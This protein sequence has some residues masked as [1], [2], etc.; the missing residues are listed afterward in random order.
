MTNTWL[1]DA[2]IYQIFIDRFAGY[3]AESDD[4]RPEFC[5]GNLKAIQEKLPYL[6]E[7]GITAIWLT[8]FLRSAD[9]HGYST[10]DFYKV[11]PHFGDLHDLKNLVSA[12]HAQ[13]IRL[14]MDFTANHVSSQ[15][16]FFQAAQNDPDSEYRQWFYFQN[17]G[18]YTCFL[19]FD[20]LPKLNL[21]YQP[22]REHVIGAAEYWL[23]E[24]GLDGFR[25][26]HVIGPSDSF[27]KEFRQRIKALNPEAVMLGEAVIFSVHPENLKTLRVP[28]A[29]TYYYLPK[30]L[31]RRLQ[32][33][34]LKHY[35]GMMDGVIDYTF[36]F[37]IWRYYQGHLTLH[38]FRQILDRHYLQFPSDF[39]LAACVE[40]HDADRIL[41]RTKGS[42]TDM[43]EILRLQFGQNQPQI[44]YYGSEVGMTHAEKVVI[45]SGWA[46]DLPAR[47][48]M[49][50]EPDKH[51]LEIYDFYKKLIAG[52]K[53][54][55][56]KR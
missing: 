13:G 31:P 48:K 2:I 1:N 47:H 33:N 23:R 28:H 34:L 25:L 32:T 5:G 21:D 39:A 15:H 52:K 18:S 49:N 46:G 41:Y 3:K 4:T 7:L 22:A 37:L 24:T 14:L 8:P 44:I 36:F 6:T 42:E 50:W 55:T 35:V 56:S 12:C 27:W 16:E 11:D 43:K 51:E 17:N 53:L 40:N 19:N 45:N 29:W 9:Y 26:D 30:L 38:E 54:S 20:T 10:L